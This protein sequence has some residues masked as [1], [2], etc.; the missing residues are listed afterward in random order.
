MIETN[1][2]K[3]RLTKE[4]VLLKEMLEGLDSLDTMKL[5]TNFLSNNSKT[6][7]SLNFPIHNC[8]P[9]PLCSGNCYACSGPITFKNSIKKS[10]KLEHTIENHQEYALLKLVDEIT[11]HKLTN[12]RYSGGGDL[13]ENSAS[14][15][16]AV[17]ARLPNV[18]FWGF[19]RK[20][21][22]AKLLHNS[23][24]NIKAIF[25]IDSSTTEKTLNEIYANNWKTAWLYTSQ[26][27]EIPDDIYITFAN[28]KNGRLDNT[29]PTLTSECPAIRNHDVKCDSC[30]HCFNF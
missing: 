28:H 7:W 10:L 25:S 23:L 18:I 4:K 30:R 20:I 29:L 3:R 13:S 5:R 12:L 15:I 24:P 17:A 19:T 22:I 26:D 2:F 16:L 27:D 6:D 14:F 8:Y 11:R 9:T 1:L 21:S